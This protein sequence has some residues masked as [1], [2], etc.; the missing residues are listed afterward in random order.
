MKQ[1]GHVA[2][3][4]FELYCRLLRQSIA[5][6]KGENPQRIFRAE[7]NVDF[8][9]FSAVP[10]LGNAKDARNSHLILKDEA[11]DKFRGN[12]IFATV[13]ENYI[14][15][16][17]VRIDVFRK[18]ALAG[19]PEDVEEVKKSLED[20]FGPFPREL[21]AFCK[22]A[23]IRCLAE[24][25]GIVNLTTEA[26][27]IKARR[28]NGEFIKIGVNFPILEEISPLKRLRELKNF[29]LQI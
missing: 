25:K 16:T 27:R 8:V 2:G 19:T 22:I 4:G 1:S 5:G 26:G 3:V 10:E 24:A 7:I 9:N 12:K 6:L 21:S 20:R 18:L 17:R 28:P 29:L 23:E 11:D 14:G 13:P 15:D